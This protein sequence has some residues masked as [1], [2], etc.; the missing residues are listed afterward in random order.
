[1][2]KKKKEPKTKIAKQIMDLHGWSSALIIDGK[3][4]FNTLAPLSSPCLNDQHIFHLLLTLFF[5]LKHP[6]NDINHNVELSLRN[7]PH[8]MTGLAHVCLLFTLMTIH[9]RENF[10]LT[11]GREKID[12]LVVVLESLIF[13]WF[14]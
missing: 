11:E 3:N 6:A 9:L 7:I 8:I 5:F 1:M 2:K 10:M 13:I 4:Q 14:H 12:L